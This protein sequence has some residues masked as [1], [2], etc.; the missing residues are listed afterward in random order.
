MEAHVG[1]RVIVNSNKVGRAKQTGEII[2][3]I[4]GEPMRALYRVRWSD[5]R[6]SLVSVGSDAKIEPASTTPGTRAATEM[7]HVTI[8]LN[9]VEDSTNCR[10]TA[11]M[12]SSIGAF[13]GCGESRRNPA[14]PEVPMIGEELAVSRALI[15][16]AQRLDAAA[17][18][19][20]AAFE[21][22]N[23]HLVS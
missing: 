6:V 3:V 7:R 19:E 5:G 15:D 8:E 16:L 13:V 10:A 4:P 14:D 17:R 11:T 23:V 18:D 2:E 22:R 20:I 1:D 9:L 12:Q 21:H